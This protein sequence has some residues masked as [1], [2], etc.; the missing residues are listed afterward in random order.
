MPAFALP[1]RSPLRRNI[2]CNVVSLM[3][4]T[5]P[6]GTAEVTT[7]AGVGIMACATRERLAR[8]FARLETIL[9]VRSCLD[10]ADFQKSSED[11]IVWR[12]LL[13]LEFQAADEKIAD[14]NGV[15][16]PRR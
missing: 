6:G 4:P 12:E 5:N 16:F 13:E 15:A 7:N 14:G 3:R 10:N 1:G 8:S 9:I 11:R 2:D